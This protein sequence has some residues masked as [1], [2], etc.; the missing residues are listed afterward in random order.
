MNWI[1]PENQKR[2][3]DES[4]AAQCEAMEKCVA[5]ALQRGNFFCLP[6]LFEVPDWGAKLY[7]PVGVGF[8][9]LKFMSQICGKYVP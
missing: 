7:Q 8:V 4:V 5:P 6:L 2:L 1:P 9:W 3:S